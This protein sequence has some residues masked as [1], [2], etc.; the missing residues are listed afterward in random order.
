MPAIVIYILKCQIS[1]AI[2]WCFYQLLLRKLTFYGMNR[3]YLLGYACL[4]FLLPLIHVV[5]PGEGADAG[6][7]K[8][9]HYIPVLI[10]PDVLNTGASVLTWWNITLLVFAAGSLALA[11][12][13]VMRWMSLT[14][15]RKEARLIRASA[16]QIYQVDKPIIPFSFGNAIYIN[17][18]LHTQ[19][20]CEE[21][22]LHE[23]VHVRQRHTVDI[24][25]AEVL[26]IVSWFNP[27][28]WLIRYSIRQNLEFIADQQVLAS[29]L[30]RKDYQYH[31][32]KVVGEPI[33]RLANNFNFSSL[34]KRIVM[35]NKS[36]SARLHIVKFL[37]I[38]PLLGVLLVA[39]RDKVD[40]PTY[41]GSSKEGDIRRMINDTTPAP[42]LVIGDKR[43]NMPMYVINE[44]E[45]TGKMKEG[46]K[47]D[48]IE[49][50]NVLKEA[51]A[52]GPR[53]VHGVILIYMK[54]YKITG[55]VTLKDGTKI[56]MDDKIGVSTPAGTDASVGVPVRSDNIIGVTVSDTVNAVMADTTNVLAGRAPRAVVRIRDANILEAPLYILD[57]K[58]VTAAEVNSIDPA[59]IASVNVI[60]NEAAKAIYGSRGA[61]GVV[62]IASKQPG[63]KGQPTIT[64][65]TPGDTVRI[66]A[67]TITLKPASK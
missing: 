3:W 28:S 35:M 41:N 29:G 30:D 26:C 66:Y 4:S 10:K 56:K 46:L 45:A 21:I 12:R 6:E 67:D 57:G 48:D 5:L 23:Y 58:V 54:K 52:F 60:K 7:I 17:S 62:M 33:Y 25:L 53:A 65:I 55:T 42:S 49:S 9:I 63:F 18:S 16:V 39:F 47:P 27:F 37:F 20:E 61:N 22:I 24:M 59:T 15:I 2:I 19:K 43:G 50:I 38:V 1:L 36:R 34:K 11:A 14:R 40:L 31:L 32:L 64:S 51:S 13:L 8:V 44:K